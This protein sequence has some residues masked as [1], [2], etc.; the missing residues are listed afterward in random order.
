MPISQKPNGGTDQTITEKVVPHQT[1]QPSQEDPHSIYKER[2]L[3]NM[4]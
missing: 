3:H 2:L 1:I 4:A